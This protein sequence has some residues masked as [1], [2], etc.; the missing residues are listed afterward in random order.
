MQPAASGP[1]CCCITRDSRREIGA[2]ADL[3]SPAITAVDAKTCTV[4]DDM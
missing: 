1:L 2:P 4:R 3:G